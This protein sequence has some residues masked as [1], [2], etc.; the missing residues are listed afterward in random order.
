M[1][2]E[3]VGQRAA[4]DGP[5]GFDDRRLPVDR[6]ERRLGFV[7]DAA[8][9]ELG[10]VFADEPGGEVETTVDACGDAGGGQVLAVLDPALVEVLGA[11]V[12]EDVDVRPVGRGRS[13]VEQAGGGEDQR[14]TRTRR[15]RRCQRRRR[16][17]RSAAGSRT[18]PARVRHRC[19]SAPARPPTSCSSSRNWLVS[20]VAAPARHGEMPLRSRV[21]HR[22]SAPSRRGWGNESGW[23]VCEPSLVLAMTLPVTARLILDT[24]LHGVA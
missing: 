21:S 15:S 12:L 24:W 6:S 1:V 3:H 17:S 20:V 5:Q 22:T 4:E 9:D 2:R 13:V 10:G 11:E 14:A 19:S 23:H 16:R 18:R 8:L 7:F